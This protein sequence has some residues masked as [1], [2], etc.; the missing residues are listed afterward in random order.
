[1]DCRYDCHTLDG[2][3]RSSVK[4]RKIWKKRRD[5]ERSA[6]RRGRVASIC[7]KNIETFGAGILL[8]TLILCGFLKVSIGQ[9][10]DMI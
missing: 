8:E 2:F 7:F 4:F 6:G 9:I 10:V 3:T 1:M 5:R